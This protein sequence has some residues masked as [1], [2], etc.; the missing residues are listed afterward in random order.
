M[1]TNEKHSNESETMERAY[2]NYSDENIY[3]DIVSETEIDI[4]GDAIETFYALGLDR[5]RNVMFFEYWNG[6]DSEIVKAV[7]NHAS[8]DIT[9]PTLRK[10][11]DEIEREAKH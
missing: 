8:A 6:L 1:G 10:I 2:Y 4:F 3:F 11:A 7:E 9:E 5:K